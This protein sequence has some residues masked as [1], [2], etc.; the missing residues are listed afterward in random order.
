MNAPSTAP[1][2][3]AARPW[4]RARSYAQFRVGDVFRH[5]WGRTMTEADAVLFSTATLAF[6][7]RY[8]NVEVA[9]GEGHPG[10]VVNPYLVLAVVIGLSVEDLSERS[11]A[12][13]GL[14]D[15][16]FLEP[17]HPGD[18]LTA[19]S[20]V[21]AMRRSRSNP[22]RGIV[23]W[24]TEGRNQ[25]AAVVVALTRSNLFRIEPDDASE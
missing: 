19:E 2:L 20:T 7:P 23:S 21:T 22:S 15:V 8:L 5:H 12:F 1:D 14:E 18:T 13:L 3:T 6:N 25:H 4:L 11:E 9:R 10:L 16:R 24:R 17:V